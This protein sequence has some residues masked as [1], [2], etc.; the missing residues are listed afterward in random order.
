M[1]STSS[2]TDRKLTIRELISLSLIAALLVASKEIMAFLPN[3]EPVTMLLTCTTL[4]YGLKALY[5]CYIF[6]LL[7]VLLYGFG[8]WSF[9]YLYIW[10]ILVVVVWLL[11]KVNRSWVIWAA[12]AALYGLLF[13][14]M[15]ALPYLIIGGWQMAFSYWISGI[16]F[17][18]LHFVGNAVLCGLLLKPLTQLL[19]KLAYPKRAKN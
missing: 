9:C 5:P 14:P 6:V 4:V 7:E 17:D 8:L 11:K 3:I 13:G 18:I 1:T 12:V 2:S 15:T 16:P 19:Q 10:A